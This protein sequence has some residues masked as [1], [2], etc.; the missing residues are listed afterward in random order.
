MSAEE[1]E[2][3]SFFDTLA[4][5]PIVAISV[6]QIQQLATDVLA[7]PVLHSGDLWRDI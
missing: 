2:N 6:A 4:R 5:G 1:L 3:V 7:K